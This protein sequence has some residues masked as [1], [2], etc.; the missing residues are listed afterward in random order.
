MKLGFGIFCVTMF[1]YFAVPALYGAMK[2]SDYN[3]LQSGI[4][5]AKKAGGSFVDE[6]K[7]FK[8]Y[9]EKFATGRM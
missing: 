4:Q 8:S 9:S 1:F 2:A 5:N 7:E 6:R 3:N